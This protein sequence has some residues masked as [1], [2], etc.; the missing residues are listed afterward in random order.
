MAGRLSDADIIAQIP[1]ARD[2]GERRRRAGLLAKSVTYDRRSARLLLELTNGALLGVPTASLAQLARAT[3]SQLADVQLTPSG[4]ALHFEALDADFSI[5]GLVLATIGSR[6][7][8]KAFAGSG[9]SVTSEAKTRAARLNGAKGGRPR[10]AHKIARSGVAVDESGG[11]RRYSV[12]EAKKTYGTAKRPPS[13]D[14][15]TPK[16]KPTQ[17]RR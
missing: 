17:K 1:A 5:P 2:R 7:I 3:P 4:G 10:R 12:G 16:G 15:S 9:G 14:A 8:A 6:L 11:S 13:A